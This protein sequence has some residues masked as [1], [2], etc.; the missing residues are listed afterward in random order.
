L[1]QQDTKN[2]KTIQWQKCGW[3]SCDSYCEYDHACQ[4]KLLFNVIMSLS[5][6]PFTKVLHFYQNSRD[7]CFKWSTRQHRTRN[8]I[9]S[10]KE[11]KCTARMEHLPQFHSRW[12]ELEISMVYR[13]KWLRGAGTWGWYQ[14][15]GNP[16]QY[17]GHLRLISLIAGVLPLCG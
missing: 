13:V 17:L 10:M 9:K 11:T 5:H 2:H 14:I 4:V 3:S 6:Q 7:S 16:N 12:R 8:S 1:R 15:W